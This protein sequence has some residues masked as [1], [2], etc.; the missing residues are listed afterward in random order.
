MIKV[1]NQTNKKI[2]TN[3]V[4]IYL[5]PAKAEIRYVNQSDEDYIFIALPK[6]DAEEVILK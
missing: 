4:M 3:K 2:D 1:T 6:L 5:V